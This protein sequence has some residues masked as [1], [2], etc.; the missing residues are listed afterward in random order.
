MELQ[1]NI[2]QKYSMIATAFLDNF[3][4][5]GETG[6]SLC[7]YHHDKL[8]ADIWSGYKDL[9]NEYALSLYSLWHNHRFEIFE[10]L[11]SDRLLK[12]KKQL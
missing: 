11:F 5:N 2:D 9:K 8:V 1:G 12:K 4:Y 10:A 7:V 6:A 3:K